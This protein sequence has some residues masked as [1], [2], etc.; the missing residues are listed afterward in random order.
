MR[1]YVAFAAVGILLSLPCQLQAVIITAKSATFADVSSAVASASAGD[2]VSVPA[3]NASWTSPLTI[4]KPI[5]VRGAGENKTIILDDIPRVKGRRESAGGARG[6]APGFSQFV[7]QRR[8]AHSPNAGSLFSRSNSGGAANASIVRAELRA[9]EALRIT[10]FT[11]KY[12]SANSASDAAIVL[13][14]T[15][16]AIRVDHCHFD[17]LYTGH[18]IQLS[19]WLYGV[20]DH[21]TFDIR[22]GI[23][24]GTSAT[25]LVSH[26]SWGN[27]P[28]GWGSWTDPPYFG[29]EKF[30][31][32]EDNVINNLS[33][34]PNGGS[35]DAARGGRYVA[36]HN[37]FNNSTI[38][39]HGSDTGAGGLYLR[40]TRAIEIYNNTFHSSHLQHPAGQCRG[41]ALLWHDN[42]YSG[43]FKNG[44]A[45]KVYRLFQGGPVRQGTW[46]AANGTSPWDCNAT[47]K[48]GTH[49]DGHAPYT[50]TTGTHTGPNDSTVVMVSGNPWQTN[51]WAGYSVTNTT[52]NS[53]YFNGCNYILSSTSNTLT[54]APFNDPPHPKFNTGDT[55]AIH[56]VLIV[57]DQPGRGKGDLI[58]GSPNNAVAAWPHQALEPCYSWN[59]TLNGA[60]LGFAPATA[61]SLLREGV[62]YYN[63][64]P[65]PGYRPY[66]YPHPLTKADVKPGQPSE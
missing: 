51:Q 8:G 63:N 19:G 53:P 23:G 28:S 60:N 18:N 20:I 40:G 17:Q 64:T 26:A 41:G 44:M 46:G 11:F 45:L 31:F 32:F 7:R 36:R 66:T 48:D 21:C 34:A 52:S 6:H 3:G 35:I 61:Q 25:A 4:T 38:F 49:V 39:Y 10:G 2:T 5:T 14:G 29:S 57:L 54:L 59:N 22:N 43:T 47:E 65:M 56:K 13:S 27:Q 16:P 42:D 12:G 9:S 50:F 1:G 15:C 37:T 62:D 55:F 33:N 24:G 30:I 58:R